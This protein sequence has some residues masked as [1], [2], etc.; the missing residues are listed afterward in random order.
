MD[1]NTIFITM[2]AMI[3]AHFILRIIIVVIED[4]NHK[5]TSC[6]AVAL[7]GVALIVKLTLL[8]S[9]GGAVL[10]WSAGILAGAFS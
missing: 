7:R 2:I 8:I 3:V 1:Q 4:V 6:V 10:W 5:F 9:I